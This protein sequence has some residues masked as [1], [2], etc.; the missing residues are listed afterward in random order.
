MQILGEPRYL[1]FDAGLW[2]TTMPGNSASCADADMA[3]AAKS[4]TIKKRFIVLA[5]AKLKI[6]N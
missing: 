4:I 6:K 2:F 3:V 1:P 5:Q